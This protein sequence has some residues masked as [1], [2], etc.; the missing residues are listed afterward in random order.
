MD[1][2]SEDLLN[3]SYKQAFLFT[4]NVLIVQEAVMPISDMFSKDYI[5]QLNIN[6]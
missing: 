4:E 6:A 3:M 2:L 5:D 1:Y